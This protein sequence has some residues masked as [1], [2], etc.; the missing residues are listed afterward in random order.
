MPV[1]IAIIGCDGT[2]NAHL[3]AYLT[4]YNTEVYQ[5]QTNERW[6]VIVV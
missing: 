4:I 5:K 2:V 6:G 3:S 1:Q